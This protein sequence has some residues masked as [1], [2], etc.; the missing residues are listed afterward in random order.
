MLPSRGPIQVTLDETA[1]RLTQCR[2]TTQVRILRRPDT[3]PTA[4]IGDGKQPLDNAQT[5]NALKSQEKQTH[6]HHQQQVYKQP[7]QQKFLHINKNPSQDSNYQ[8]LQN[9]H[10]KRVNSI[11]I[12]DSN[13]HEA[14]S[15][16]K[17]LLKTYQE[18]ADEYAKARLRIL[19]SAFPENDESIS[20]TNATGGDMMAANKTKNLDVQKSA[21]SS[22]ISYPST[23]FS[24]SLTSNL[25]VPSSS[26]DANSIFMDEQIQHLGAKN[27]YCS[28][29]DNL[30]LGDQN[31][32][33]K[34]YD[35]NGDNWNFRN[36]NK[37][38]SSSTG[39]NS[40]YRGP[41]AK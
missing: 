17:K 15:N 40:N 5:N 31:S 23:S 20:T 24:S 30:T 27:N 11:P 18:R 22:C 3:K 7:Q 8:K 38:L 32:V 16:N 1:S 2:P 10:Q 9:C 39:C 35:N 21:P 6:H 19:G 25:S 41:K 34:E 26:S 33:F 12:G 14:A 37:S 29:T 4:T 13:K 28:N 36:T